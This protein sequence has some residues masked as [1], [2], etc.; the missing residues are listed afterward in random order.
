MKKI[1]NLALVA[2]LAL[3]STM[4][5]YAQYEEGMSTI[6]PR[7][8]LTLS[9]LSGDGKMKVDPTFGVEYE[10]YVNDNFSFA[11]GL[12][13]TNQGAKY[14]FLDEKNQEQ[15]SKIN[16]YYGALPITANYYLLP[17]LAVKAGIQPAF[18]VKANIKMDG[19]NVDFDRVVDTIFEGENNTMNKFDLSVPVGLSYEFYR[20]TLDARYNIGVTNLIKGDKVH[21]KV[22]IV[23]LGYKF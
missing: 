12:L 10:Y 5:A 8:G 11:A 23:T 16:I 22:F 9:N 17:G 19:A 15:S 6:Q 1:F 7:I 20:V 14:E 18:R 4:S 2:I 13:F 21:Q 3:C